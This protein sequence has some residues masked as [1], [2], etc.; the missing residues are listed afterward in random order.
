MRILVFRFVSYLLIPVG[1]VDQ[2]PYREYL[3]QDSHLIFI[4][5]TSVIC[6][7]LAEILSFFRELGK[8]GQLYRITRISA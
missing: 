1:L 3:Y 4:A 5:A 2:S 7:V 8:G 6:F